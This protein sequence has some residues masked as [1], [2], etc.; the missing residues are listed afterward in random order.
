MQYD[1]L[2]VGGGSAGCVLA[3]RLSANPAT[4]VCLLEA[5]PDDNSLLVRIPAG[6]IALMRSRKRNWRYYSVPQK[7]LNNRQVYVPRGKTLGGSSAVNAMCYTR[8][9]RWDYDHWASLGNSGWSWD[10]VLPLFR[11]AENNERGADD[12][13]G[14]KGPLSVSNMRIQRPITD[15][16]V[17]AAQAAGYPFNP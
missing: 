2:I 10:E 7:A 16:W 8:G 12:F 13:H 15:A 1:Y 17:A 9:N 11:R 3:N 5:G 6:I 14:N 4:R